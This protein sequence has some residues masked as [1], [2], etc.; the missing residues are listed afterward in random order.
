MTNRTFLTPE[1]A[2]RIRATL[3]KAG[4]DLEARGAAL[5]AVVTEAM[6]TAQPMVS[7]SLEAIRA[8]VARLDVEK[9]AA[10]VNRS[11]AGFRQ[12]GRPKS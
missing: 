2:A 12:M 9:V 3:Q 11:L 10:D 5:H 8:E 7:R 6:K 4:A 1:D